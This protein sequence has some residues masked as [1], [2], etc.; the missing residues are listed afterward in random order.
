MLKLMAWECRMT[1]VCVAT[2]FSVLLGTTNPT[3]SS[4]D[5]SSASLPK[6]VGSCFRLMSSGNWEF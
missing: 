5:L 2:L 3:F 1:R 6:P 4:L